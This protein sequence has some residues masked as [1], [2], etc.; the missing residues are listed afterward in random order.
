MKMKYVNAL[1]FIFDLNLQEERIEFLMS[2]NSNSR[3]QVN[4]IIKEALFRTTFNN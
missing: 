3:F 4:L 1:A 2:A